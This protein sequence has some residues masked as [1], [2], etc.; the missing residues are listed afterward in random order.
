MKSDSG[1]PRDPHAVLSH[2]AGLLGAQ[3]GALGNA[4][5]VR[6]AP[7]EPTELSEKYRGVLVAGE[8]LLSYQSQGRLTPTP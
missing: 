1:C 2:S 7:T 8:F 4:A 5:S 6:S 3:S